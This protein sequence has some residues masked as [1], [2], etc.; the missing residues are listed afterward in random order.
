MA[1]LV[2][3]DDQR[4]L[5]EAALSFC[6]ENAPLSVLRRLRDTRDP[7][8]Y[9]PDL[10][11]QMVELGWTGMTVPEAYGGFDFGYRGLGIV[12]EAS[13]RSLLNS[14]LISTVL[15]SATAL[16]FGGSEAQKQEFLPAIVNGEMIMALA[17]DEAPHHAPA[18]VK[19]TA[20]PGNDGFVLNGSK[21]MVL[22][23]QIADKLIVSA[24]TSGSGSEQSGISLFL[25]NAGSVGVSVRQTG[26]VDSRNAATITLN[27]VKVSGDDLLGPCDQGLPLLERILDTGCIG[28]AA[29][30]L[31]SMQEVFE[32]I[33]DYLRQREQFGVPIGAFQALQHR[34]AAMYCDIE[35]CKSVVLAAL[36]ALDNDSEQVPRLASLAKAKC[37]EVFFTVS[38]EGIQMH[39]GIGMTDEFDIGFFLK[40]AR[41]VQTLFGDQIFHRD[42]YARLQG[43]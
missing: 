24:R 37:S 5:K 28:L 34:A 13:G 41:V 43:F 6:R 19:L 23:G 38:N 35:L 32:R 3:D 7:L 8:G 14:P 27:N 20:E 30:M 36:D 18:N 39:G 1:A 33:L 10:W 11:R 40:R 2:L 26:M 22:D 42:R 25:V 15:L 16:D 21:V 12:L 29:E 4:L 9:D 17:V 31:G